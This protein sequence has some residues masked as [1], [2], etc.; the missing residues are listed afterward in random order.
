M[1]L[2]IKINKHVKEKKKIRRIIIDTNNFN[3]IN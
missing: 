1:L 2:K 3:W